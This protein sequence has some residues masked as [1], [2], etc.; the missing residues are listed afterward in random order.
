MNREK[1]VA[2]GGNWWRPVWLAVASVSTCSGALKGKGGA[3]KAEGRA[4]AEGR[5]V[6]SISCRCHAG[7]PSSTSIHSNSLVNCYWSKLLNFEIVCGKQY[8]TIQ[9]P[10]LPELK[11]PV[12]PFER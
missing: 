2:T 9:T 6:G 8:Q 11:L 7:G 4:Q 12:V 5:C 1:D 3:A 10:E